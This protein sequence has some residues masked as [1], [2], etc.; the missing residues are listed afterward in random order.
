MTLTVPAAFA[1]PTGQPAAIYRA[2]TTVPS[3]PGGAASNRTFTTP[4]PVTLD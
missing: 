4:T 3:R 1:V 2:S